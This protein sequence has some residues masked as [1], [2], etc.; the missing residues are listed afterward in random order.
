MSG[1]EII[2]LIS[3]IIA[4]VEGSLKL[5]EAIDDASGLP[6]S[7]RHAA[8]RLPVI[9]NTLEAALEGLA[10]E[11]DAPSARQ[12]AALSRMLRSC[13]DKAMTL[14]KIIQKVIPAANASP[15]N[16]LMKAV[17]TLPNADKVDDLMDGILSDLQVLTANRA[18]KT[19]SRAQMQRL[20]DSAEWSDMHHIGDHGRTPT[21]TLNNAS[22]G[23]QYV[24]SGQGDQN[25]ATG[26]GIQINGTSSGPFYF[27][28]A[29]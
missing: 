5:Y 23:T 3:S 15:M 2:G 10:E 26:K 22:L 28:L 14:Q 13:R 27:T 1:A 9:Q 25:V 24:Y 21:I 16:R 7:F 8:D 6:Q 19:A 4:I 11:E 20:I 17:K 18:L 29:N 12:R